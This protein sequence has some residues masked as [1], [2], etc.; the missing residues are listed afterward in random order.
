MPASCRADSIRPRTRSTR[1]WRAS[2][3]TPRRVVFA[4]GEEEKIVRAAVAF[5]N[6]G[7]GT[8][9]LIGR[10]DRVMSTL[11]GLGMSDA[12][13]IEIHNARLSS[14]NHNYT[15]YLYARLQRRGFL[16]RDCQRMV[17]QDRNVFAACMVATG[18]AD[19]IVTGLTRSPAVC[20]EDIMQVL[21]PAPGALLFGLTLMVGMRGTTIFIADTLIHAR[22]TPEQIA[23]IATGVAKA[24]RRLGHEPRVALLSHSTFGNPIP[25]DRP[26]DPARRRDPRRAGRR[27]RIRWRDEPGRRARSVA[28]GALSVLPPDRT[29]QR[30]GDAGPALGA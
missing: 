19:A 18:E 4:E 13:G 28:A 12:A 15:D 1:S 9:V 26:H 27:F 20:L 14:V 7:Y 6:A 24:A 8:P 16:L 5:R 17:N 3:P 23:D 21:D 30:A 29:G 22:P 10:D 2:E 11:A 25:R